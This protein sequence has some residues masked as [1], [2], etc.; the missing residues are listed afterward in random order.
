MKTFVFKT[1]F[2][3]IIIVATFLACGDDNNDIPN[4]A[5]DVVIIPD[6]TYQVPP[7][8]DDCDIFPN[9]TI[10]GE[11]GYELYRIS[12]FSEHGGAI[13][14]CI[15]SSQSGCYIEVWDCYLRDICSQWKKYMGHFLCYL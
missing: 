8:C 6:W 7:G 2:F 14:T 11:P 1:T 12:C 9:Q 5:Y 4:D 13:N 10:I 15:Y 3:C